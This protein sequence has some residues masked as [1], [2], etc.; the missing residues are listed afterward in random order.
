MYSTPANAATTNTTTTANADQV[1]VW[2]P[3]NTT[4][5]VVPGDSQKYRIYEGLAPTMQPWENGLRINPNPGTFDWWYWQTF[6]T[7]GSNAQFTW[8]VKPYMDNNGPLQPSIAISIRTPNGTVLADN[9]RIN[10]HQFQ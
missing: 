6:L 10:A 1:N 3:T 8:V 9:I 2:R 5:H 4:N 7:D